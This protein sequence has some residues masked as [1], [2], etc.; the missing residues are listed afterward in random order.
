M[1]DLVDVFQIVLDKI[2]ITLA[3]V[4]HFLHLQIV[5]VIQDLHWLLHFVYLSVEMELLLEMKSTMMV[6][7]EESIQ[8]VLE[9]I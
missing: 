7:W 1:V 2:L 9:Q 4:V 8:H 6:I 5:F 3:Q